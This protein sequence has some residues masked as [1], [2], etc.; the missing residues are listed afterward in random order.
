MNDNYSGQELLKEIRERPGDL[1][2]RLMYADWL[3]DPD[4]GQNTHLTN[5]QRQAN[6]A[7]GNSS[8]TSA[9]PRT[10]KS[11]RTSGSDTGRRRKPCSKSTGRNGER[12]CA[13]WGPT[14]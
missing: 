13:S 3:Q 7:R 5:Q 4:G 9:G 14:M 2:A 12:P 6:E 8:P 1:T 10:P 11:S